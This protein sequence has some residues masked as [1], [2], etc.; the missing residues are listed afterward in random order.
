M[1]LTRFERLSPRLSTVHS[2]IRCFQVCVDSCS[3]T[4]MDSDMRRFL[5]VAA[6]LC[7]AGLGSGCAMFDPCC[8]YP[9]YGASVWGTMECCPPVTAPPVVCCPPPAPAWN[10]PPQIYCP[11]P[12]PPVYC[13]TPQPPVYCPTPQ[14]YAYC[15]PPE[16]PGRKHPHRFFQRWRNDDDGGSCPACG[17]PEPL[18]RFDDDDG[19]TAEPTCRHRRKRCCRACSKGP[20]CDSPNRGCAR[21]S[22]TCARTTPAIANQTSAISS[23]F[24]AIVSPTCAVASPR[25]TIT[26]PTCA[27]PFSAGGCRSGI[28][29]C[30][31]IGSGVHLPDGFMPYPVDT[32]NGNTV[33][34]GI[35]YDEPVVPS[36]PPTHPGTTPAPPAEPPDDPQ[37][38]P[39][40]PAPQLLP[41]TRAPRPEPP[42]APLPSPDAVPVLR[43][44][45]ESSEEPTTFY[46]PRILPSTSQPVGRAI[47]IRQ[48]EDDSF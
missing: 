30:H 17:Y 38:V 29:D 10:P 35:P 9:P 2:T 46:A 39:P 3:L 36:R 5:P 19:D 45:P 21:R 24:P 37:P 43:L 11:T 32:Y 42:D 27:V 33:P 18:T 4:L 1:L 23:Q 31:A 25:R 48:I 12:Q 20:E 14:P 47:P 34:G 13:P 44:L 15:P 40:R 6:I 16:S 7:C 26:R 8:T 28:C 22:C 41:D